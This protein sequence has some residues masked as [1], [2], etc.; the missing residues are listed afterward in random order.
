MNSSIID[1]RTKYT[2]NANTISLVYNEIKKKILTENSNNIF[3]I[4]PLFQG[5]SI[6]GETNKIL[7]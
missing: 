6:K 1:N 3:W 7:I 5:R 4:G 2:Q